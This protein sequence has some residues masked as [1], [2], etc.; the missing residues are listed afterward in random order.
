M[1]K[2]EDSRLKLP[3]NFLGTVA[4]LLNTPPP[5]KKKGKRTAKKASKTKG[6]GR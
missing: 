3:G 1:A 5:G 4:A 2:R 6:R